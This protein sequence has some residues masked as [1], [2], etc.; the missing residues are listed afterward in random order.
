MCR[1]IRLPGGWCR[2][3]SGRRANDLNALPRGAEPSEPSIPSGALKSG[4][5]VH[6]D[7]I[8][9]GYDGTG[10][11]ASPSQVWPPA[12]LLGILHIVC[13]YVSMVRSRQIMG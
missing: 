11:H 7:P 13:I 8:C 4:L 5:L 10:V 3:I 12:G 2:S 6:H 1:H 9:T